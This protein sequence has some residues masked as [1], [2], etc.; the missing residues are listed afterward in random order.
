MTPLLLSVGTVAM[1]TLLL[2]ASVAKARSSYPSD[3]PRR[4]Q[5][6]EEVVLG[7][8]VGSVALDPDSYLRNGRLT[9]DVVARLQYRF[10]AEPAIPLVIGLADG[11]IRT[12]GLIDRESIPGCRQRQSCEVQIDVT[13]M[14]AEYFDIV[15]VVVDVSIQ[16]V[17]VIQFGFCKFHAE[18][19]HAK[20]FSRCLYLLDVVCNPG[21]HLFRNSNDKVLSPLQ[22]KHRHL[23]CILN[24][25]RMLKN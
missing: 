2:T 8:R 14:P 10:L 13:V 1:A 7:T 18:D 15:K 12:S 11:V 20:R 3:H 24:K 5:V 22:L 19:F 9:A 21:R 23:A 17:T 4:L 16:R 6:E 25:T